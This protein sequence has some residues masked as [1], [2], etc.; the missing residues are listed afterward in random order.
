MC[1]HMDACM[2]MYLT[3]E[4]LLPEKRG[5]RCQSLAVLIAQGMAVY[6]PRLTVSDT[7][8]ESWSVGIIRGAVGLP[9]V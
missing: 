4:V 3:L 1:I 6:V 5:S 2:Y 9:R 7:C 8:T